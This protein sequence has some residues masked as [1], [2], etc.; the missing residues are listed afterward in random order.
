MAPSQQLNNPKICKRPANAPI[1]L[2]VC[3]GRPEAPLV[4]HTA[5]LEI[6]R[7]GSYVNTHVRFISD[8]RKENTMNM[9]TNTVLTKKIRTI[10]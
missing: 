6:S 10:N 7:R 8:S 9:N 5:Q 4:A 1:R 3:A 2:R